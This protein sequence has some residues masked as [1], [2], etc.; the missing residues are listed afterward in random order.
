MS[1][2]VSISYAGIFVWF[3]FVR[4]RRLIH[5]SCATNISN[6]STPLHNALNMPIVDISHA[7]EGE[8]WYW[9]GEIWRY[10]AGK[11]QHHKVLA[12]WPWVGYFPSQRLNFFIC[13][14]Q[15]VI[16][17]EI[18]ECGEITWNIMLKI[19]AIITKIALGDMWLKPGEVSQMR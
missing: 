10:H 4:E 9:Y 1:P 18:Q 11:H 14:V 13:K 3:S 12:E 15:K 7:G 16:V 19:W 6:N 5:S 8:S 2:W 17:P